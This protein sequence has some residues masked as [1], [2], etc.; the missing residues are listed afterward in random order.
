M[1]LDI[2]KISKEKQTKPQEGGDIFSYLKKDITF[3]KGMSDKGKE[4]FY[5]EMSLM[6]NSGI[7]IDKALS[8][9]SQHFRKA[10]E[11]KVVEDIRANLI[12]GLSFSQ[13]IEQ[14]EGFSPYEF[15]SIRIGEE[16]GR[17][18]LVL[19]QLALF[20]K[21]KLKQRKQVINA[22]TYPVV[23]LFTAFAAVGF[24][25]NFVVPIFTEVFKR[26]DGDLPALTKRVISMSEFITSHF[27]VMLLGVVAIVVIIVYFHNTPFFR[28]YSSLFLMKIPV[29]G[30]T[31]TKVYTA[32]FCHAMTL[33]T[34][35][36]VPMLRAIEMVEK[37]IGFYPF[38]VA[39][40]GVQQ[41]IL[42]GEYLYQTLSEYSFFESKMVALIKVAEEVNR[43]DTVFNELSQQYT[44][45]VENSVSIVS[46]I[47]E[48]LLI[49]TVGL[50]VGVILIAMYLP[51][52]QLST[53]FSK[54]LHQKK[55]CI[56]FAQKKK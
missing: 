56:Y 18:E 37:M 11:K 16:I 41:G 27:A 35:A 47:L 8:I 33:L 36:H 45:E 30:V 28:K 23:V 29:V 14:A 54:K 55:N 3:T 40:R 2:S 24:L 44:E 15:Y 38:E 31:I 48:P 19:N 53:S 46:S 51:L 4:M 42:K 22:L 25:M 21:R 43:M 13:A 49:V 32:R 12:S 9:I 5:N 7:D 17:I 50:L 1:A 10:K 34:S 26:F 39:L 20:Y 6:L 52:F